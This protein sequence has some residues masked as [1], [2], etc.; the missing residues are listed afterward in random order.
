MILTII[1]KRFSDPMMNSYRQN[2]SAT[3]ARRRLLVATFVVA[4]IVGIDFV[5]HGALRRPVQAA[6]AFLWE[7][8]GS[9][10]SHVALAGFFESRASL[11]EENAALREEITQLQE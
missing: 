5:S 6:G 3:R 2:N 4:L 11:A 9:V 8:S 7:R 10:V 1:M